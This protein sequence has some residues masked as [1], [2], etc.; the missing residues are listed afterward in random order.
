MRARA[1]VHVCV[2]MCGRVC[3]DGEGGGGT[4]VCRRVLTGLR[5]Q[6]TKAH[7]PWAPEDAPRIHYVQQA[8]MKARDM[9]FHPILQRY[10]DV[11]AVC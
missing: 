9:L 3:V 8:E 7:L 6:E 4:P 5:V 11:R 10:S 2:C 1:C